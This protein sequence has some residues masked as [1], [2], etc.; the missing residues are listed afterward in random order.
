MTD[1]LW[2]FN[3]DST[4][5]RKFIHLNSIPRE[6]IRTIS[7]NEN[8]KSKREWEF[9]LGMNL[10][11]YTPANELEELLV[12]RRTIRKASNTIIDEVLVSKLLQ[13][14]CGI[15]DNK[16]LL[17]C[18]PSPGAT[19][20][21]TVFIYIETLNKNILFRYNPYLHKLEEFC[22]TDLENVNNVI[23]NEDFY[24]LKIKI[25]LASDFQ[26]IEDK[27]HFAAYRLICQETGHIAQN[28]CL[29]STMSN[30]NCICYGGFYEIDFQKIVGKQYSLL[31]VLLVG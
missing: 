5:F 19:Y 13:F 14:C 11:M 9:K 22:E 8:I 27:Y 1:K 26:L 7:I 28:I 2:H 25:F 29:Y 31:Y 24:E 15:S 4:E 30:I 12:N 23:K 3:R 20:A 17:F 10:N 16:N 18:Y 21:V 6:E